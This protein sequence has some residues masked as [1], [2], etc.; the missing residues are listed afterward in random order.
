MIEVQSEK[1]HS[2]LL[3]V[4]ADAVRR[5]SLEASGFTVVEVTDT[6]LWTRPH[7]AVERVRAARA[8]LLLDRRADGRSVS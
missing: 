2:A 1:Y 6:E 8:Q 4:S 3:D 7:V 5:A